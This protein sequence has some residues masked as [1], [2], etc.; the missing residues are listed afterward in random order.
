MIIKDKSEDLL[1][2]LEDTSNIKG[3]ASRLY[4][5]QTK[6]ELILAIKQC[7]KD[8]VPFTVSAGRTGT[9]GGSTPLDGVI[10]SCE[11]LVQLK[12]DSLSRSAYLEAGVSLDTLEKE[13]NRQGLSLRASPTEN[14]ACIGGVIAT[15][16]CGV[17]GFRYGS[18]RNYIKK[19][20]VVLASG[21]ILEIVRGKYKAKG[22]IFDFK[23]AGRRFKFSLCSYSM[24]AVKSQAGYYI[25]DNMDLIDLFIGSEGTLGVILSCEVSLEELAGSIFDG[26][27]FFP[28]EEEALKFTAKVKQLKKDKLMDPTSLEFFDRNSLD[29]L[30]G[31]YS[32]MPDDS[33]AVYFEQ[34]AENSK[35]QD[36]LIDKW[37]EL[38]SQ[39]GALGDNTIFADTL[40]AREKVF[41]FRHKLPQL[42]NEFLRRKGQVKTATD[43]AVSDDKFLQMY[44]YYKDKAESSGLDYVNFGHIGQSHL[45]FNFLPKNDPQADQA[46]K[47]IESFCRKAVLLSGTISAEHG[48]GK[49][50]KPYLKLMYSASQ[51]KEMATLKKYFDPDCLLNLD[52]IFDKELL[53]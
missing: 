38:I 47:L 7:H 44:A 31:E 20:E 46:R 10:V 8:K 41:A 26:I 50:K 1:T 16:A 40:V 24:P 6:D 15:C 36:S 33:C 18:I 49:L 22:R 34:E 29:F 2:Y 3:C 35:Q 39:S 52:N 9:T 21:E 12:I 32:F 42:I 23:A 28:E 51:I 19:I 53:V 45:H 37:Y 4:I 5:P 17:R 43:I 25:A 14:L 13:A 27:I 11:R 30:R 48:I